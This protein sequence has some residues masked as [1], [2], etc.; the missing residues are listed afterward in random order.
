MKNTDLLNSIRLTIRQHN[1]MSEEVSVENLLSINP[2]TLNQQI[3]TRSSALNLVKTCRENPDNQGLFDAFLQEYSL[4]SEEGVVL[5]CLAEA[6]LRVPDSYTLDKLI[7]EK[8]H[9]G[10]WAEHLGHSNEFLVN[11]ASAGLV[12]T[13]KILQKKPNAED[14]PKNWFGKLISRVGEPV[15][16]GAT[17]QAMKYMGQQYVLGRSIKE[18]AKRGKKDN[19]AGT[20]FSFDMLGEGAR[21]YQDAEKYFDAYLHAIQSIGAANKHSDVKLADG[22]SVKLSA[23]HPRYEFSHHQLVL[24]ELIPSVMKLAIEAKKLGIGLTIDAEEAARLDIELDVFQTLALAPELAD[25][26]GLGFVLQAYQKRAIYVVDWLVELAELSQ[27]K[28]M[29]RLVKGAYWDAEIKHAQEQGL[30]DFPVFSRKVNTDLSYQV[31]AAKLLQN[32]LHIYPQF[33]TH[34]AYTVSLIMQMASDDLQSFEFQRLH[35]MGE[36][37]YSHLIGEN[38]QNIPIRVYAPVGVHK[39]L[40]PYLV[41]RLLENGANGS[42]VNQF[43]DGKVPVEN[44]VQN[45]ESNIKMLPGRRHSRIPLAKELFTTFGELRHNSR[46]IDLDDP[47]GVSKIHNELKA[48]NQSTREV[49]A[50]INGQMSVHQLEP[51]VSPADN[52]RIVGYCSD[53]SDNDI[54]N[55]LS[56]AANAQPNWQDTD[57]NTRANILEKAADLF[58]QNTEQLV[59]LICI[60]AGRA[61]ADG[62]SEVRETVDFCR[63]YALQ[64]RRIMGQGNNERGSDS[65]NRTGICNGKGVFVCISPWN[66]P[67]AILVGQ[68]VAALVTGN[69][70]IAKPAEQTPIIAGEATKI[71]HQAGVPSEVLQLITGTGAKVGPKLLSSSVV[72]GV[73]FTGSTKTAKRIQLDLVKRGTKMPPLIAETGGQNVMIVDS[74]ALPEQVVDSVVQSAFLSAG[75]RCSALR[76][77]YLQD[78]IADNIISMLIGAIDTL[79]IGKPWHLNSDVGPVIDM[80]AQQILNEHQNRMYEQGTLLG[81]GQ[82]SDE[83]GEGSFVRPQVYEIENINQ[84]KDEV[85]GP[86]LHLIRYSANELDQVIQDINDTGYGLTLGVHSRLKQFSEHVF[87]HTSVGNTYINRNTVGAVVG[88]NPFGGHGL[89]GTGFKAGGP[90]YLLRFTNLWNSPEVGSSSDVNIK[91]TNMVAKNQIKQVKR[92]SVNWSQT[93][94][95]TRCEIL[96]TMLNK[97]QDPSFTSKHKLLCNSRI[98]WAKQHLSTVEVLPGPTGETNEL[99]LHAKGVVLILANQSSILNGY[100]LIQLISALATG[101]GVVLYTQESSLRPFL[102]NLVSVCASFLPLHL[103]KQIEENEALSTL[104][105]DDNTSLVACHNAMNIYPVLAQRAGAIIQV[106]DHVQDDYALLPYL[107][108]KTKTDNIVATGG[109]AFLLNLN[110]S[111]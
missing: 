88:V 86:I 103:V 22:I 49:G 7:E 6:L 55:A 106:V 38:N 91:R 67:L 94:V 100:T 44:L 12:L 92:V 36:L 42:F 81:Q 18:A 82:L 21:T 87:K 37:L 71:L 102:A 45:V 30:K 16:R 13:S 34:N 83:C 62:V 53:A 41:R 35:G 32:K 8:I 10:N 54:Q 66:F 101:N 29:V 84:L 63:Y 40:L 107:V 46:G 48:F 99:S 14:N 26:H 43:L 51:I 73:A 47:L 85:F 79:K 33:A 75:Q 96:V 15:V 39:D 28:L 78:D 1:L 80:K 77:L 109:N 9:L 69:S 59:A 56:S 25:W 72:A 90:H 64:A 97:L 68:V 50:I 104:L 70:V 76:V 61:I 93:L 57:V 23:L 31:C 2:L 108:E 17:L 111:S 58:E 110:E 74:T 20:R 11:V 95:N 52:N 105:L 89:S 60:E 24:D 98:L 65:S 5:M 3:E 4:S 19:L 27:K